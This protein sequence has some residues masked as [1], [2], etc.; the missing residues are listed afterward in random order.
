[1]TWRTSGTIFRFSYELLNPLWRVAPAWYGRFLV[2]RYW[3]AAMGLTVAISSARHAVLRHW[4]APANLVL[5]TLF[6]WL[7]LVIASA[8]WMP[9]ASYVCVWPLLS[10]LLGAVG[11]ARAAGTAWRRVWW[12]AAMAMPTMILVMPLVHGVYVALGPRV[13]FVPMLVLTLGWGALSWQVEAVS[14]TCRWRLPLAG[15]LLALAALIA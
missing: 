10:G 13:M 1:M 14:G 12:L 11:V 15:L 4:I 8:L 5:G 6:W 3:L 9:G 2:G 7:M